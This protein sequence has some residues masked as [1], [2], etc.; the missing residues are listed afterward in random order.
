MTEPGNS[1]RATS[2]RRRADRRRNMT[3]DF[4]AA[5][6]RRSERRGEGPE[7]T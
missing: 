7:Q 6:R 4:G 5:E 3:V 1:E 2:D